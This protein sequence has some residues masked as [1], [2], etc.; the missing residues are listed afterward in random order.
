M[1]VFVDDAPNNGN[2]AAT[3]RVL[4]VLSVLF[5]TSLVCFCYLDTGSVVGTVKQVPLLRRIQQSTTTE[6]DSSFSIVEGDIIVPSSSLSS[7]SQQ[8]S[9]TIGDHS[10]ATRSLASVPF[11]RQL[12]TNDNRNGYFYIT[13]RIDAN[14]SNYLKEMIVKGLRNLQWRSQVIRFD[15]I[16]NQPQRSIPYIHYVNSDLGCRSMLGQTDQAFE[17]DGQYIHLQESACG[18]IRT[19]QHE[20]MHALGFGHEQS[21]PDRNDYIEILWDNIIDEYNKQ[22]WK[23]NTVDSL[24]TEYDLESIMHYEPHAFSKND[25]PTIRPRNGGEIAHRDTASW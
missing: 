23:I 17:G 4:S 9:P 11:G 20:M 21:R 7:S 14:F 13:V 15:V 25:Q 1:K 24:G 2:A 19:V 3:I 10:T 8:K 16:Y 6:E 5:C 18:N 12:W 22:F